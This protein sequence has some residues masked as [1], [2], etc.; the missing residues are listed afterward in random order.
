[1][2]LYTN[3]IKDSVFKMIIKSF[4]QERFAEI[5]QKIRSGV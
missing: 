4:A 3:I 5:A 1:M 2:E